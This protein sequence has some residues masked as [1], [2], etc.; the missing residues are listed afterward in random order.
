MLLLQ[1]Q[2]YPVHLWLKTVSVLDIIQ[3]SFMKVSENENGI[4]V[5]FLSDWYVPYLVCL[6]FLVHWTI[7]SFMQ[8][9]I[10]TGVMTPCYENL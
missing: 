9:W 6:S 1:A 3:W 7:N 8:K 10:R 2:K 4:K 5:S